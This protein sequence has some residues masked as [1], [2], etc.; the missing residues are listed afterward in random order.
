VL[1]GLTALLCI[2]WYTPHG[3]TALYIHYEGGAERQGGEEGRIEEAKGRRQRQT[4]RQKQ[5]G[6]SL[7]HAQIGH[8]TLQTATRPHQQTDKQREMQQYLGARKEGL[9]SLPGLT[10]RTVPRAPT[11]LQQRFSRKSPVAGS[12]DWTSVWQA[13]RWLR[14]ATARPVTKRCC[15]QFVRAPLL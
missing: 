4:K 5:P 6:L 11:V 10:P 14:Y 7:K 9:F 3:G 12:Q 15:S 8:W 2:Y 13:A 1:C